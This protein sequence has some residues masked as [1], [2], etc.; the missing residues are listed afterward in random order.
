MRLKSLKSIQPVFIVQQH[1]VVIFFFGYNVVAVFFSLI[2]MANGAI[3]FLNGFVEAFLYTV[4]VAVATK[5]R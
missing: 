3:I 2:F 1:N 4:L 5:H